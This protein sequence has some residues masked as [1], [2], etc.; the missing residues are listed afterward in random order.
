MLAALAVCLFIIL[1]LFPIIDQI[2]VDRKNISLRM[3]ANYVL[4]E[5][6]AAFVDGEMEAVPMEIEQQNH[7]YTLTWGR[8][9]DFPE[10]M[11]GCIHYENAYG[12]TEMVCDATKK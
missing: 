1:T 11:E 3:E 10:M 12:K 9:T 6:L 2:K 4:Y 8:Q 7:I 5:R